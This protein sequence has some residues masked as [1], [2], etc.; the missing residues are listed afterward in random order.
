MKKRKVFFVCS[1]A[2]FLLPM[3]IC[4][5]ALAQFVSLDG[6]AYRRAMRADPVGVVL[7]AR[8]EANENF[9]KLENPSPDAILAH[10]QKWVNR[11]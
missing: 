3:L 2:T 8:H 5:I 6:D 10:R 1:S 9:R 7:I 4:C 11:L